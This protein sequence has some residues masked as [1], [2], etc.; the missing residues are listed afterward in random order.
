MVTQLSNKKY[1][2]IEPNFPSFLTL[3]EK[4][5]S[6]PNTSRKLYIFSF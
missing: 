2:A 4:K 6:K 1:W 5:N 3:F